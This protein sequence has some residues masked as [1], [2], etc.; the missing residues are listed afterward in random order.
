ML[1][2][3]HQ[4]TEMLAGLA[5]KLQSGADIPAAAEQSADPA[6]SVAKSHQIQRCLDQAEAMVVQVVC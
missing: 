2:E 6:A 1:T 4:V 5:S 3:A